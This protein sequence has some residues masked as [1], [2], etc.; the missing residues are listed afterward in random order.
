MSC[1]TILL[2]FCV[3]KIIFFCL[4]DTNQTYLKPAKPL[5]LLTH[6][7]KY[8][9]NWKLLKIINELM[10]KVFENKFQ[11]LVLYCENLMS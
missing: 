7:D 9:N 8:I 3:V 11:I 1:A 2:K 5:E 6:V 4:Y 10:K